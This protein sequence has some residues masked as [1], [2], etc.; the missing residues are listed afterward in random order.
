[1]LFLY[2]YAEKNS[3][4]FDLIINL[5]FLLLIL[6]KAKHWKSV[7]FYCCLCLLWTLWLF[8]RF[9]WGILWVTS[10]ASSGGAEVVRVFEL[11]LPVQSI[12]II[13]IDYYN[14]A[15]NINNTSTICWHSIVKQWIEENGLL[16]N[17]QTR[18]KIHWNLINNTWIWNHFTEI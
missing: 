1:M 13:Q 10:S 7:S 9:L 15:G 16:F 12:G 4:T 6:N 8:C 11:P 14:C 18:R 2:C 5:S 17:C 3:I